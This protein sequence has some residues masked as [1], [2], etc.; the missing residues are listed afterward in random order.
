MQMPCLGD[1]EAS[2]LGPESYPIE[3]AWSLPSGDVRSHLISPDLAW[4]DYWDNNSEVLHNISREMLRKDGVPA[5]DIAVEMNRDLAGETLF[6]DGGVYDLA[7]LN[8][9]Y[10]AAGVKPTFKF[11]E[12]E[13]LLSCAGVVDSSRRVASERLARR[14]MGDLPLHRAANDVR[15]LQRWYIRARGGM[16]Y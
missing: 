8:Q 9:L 11:G 4:G 5:H 1:F 12:F 13:T 6:F 2:G 10:H 15:L 16:R 7:W 3:V 14:D